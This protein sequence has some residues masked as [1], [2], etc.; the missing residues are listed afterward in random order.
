MLS[1]S[2]VY[3]SNGG[4]DIPGEHNDPDS[5]D[6]V[7]EEEVMWILVKWSLKKDAMNT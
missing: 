5:Q 1:N 3:D 4:A 6:I 7:A 2:K